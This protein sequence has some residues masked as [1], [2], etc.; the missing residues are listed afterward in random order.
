MMIT[1]FTINHKKWGNGIGKK[2]CTKWKSKQ[3][4]SHP[5]GSLLW[6]AS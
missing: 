6:K 2:D 5:V 1:I 3:K 4:L